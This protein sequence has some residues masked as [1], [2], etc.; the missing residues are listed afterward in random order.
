MWQIKEI[1]L[2]LVNKTSEL[3]GVWKITMTE[4]ISSNFLTLF[5]CRTL[6][7]VGYTA[8]C[9]KV[10]FRSSCSSTEHQMIMHFN[11]LVLILSLCCALHKYQPRKQGNTS[12]LAF[13]MEKI[14]LTLIFLFVCFFFLFFLSFCTKWAGTNRESYQ[15]LVRWS[16]SCGRLWC[17]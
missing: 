9:K 11:R 6:K 13:K 17:T 12:F 5:V 3:W 16:L 10:Q 15:L 1:K 4:S 14:K 8:W 7:L 2:N